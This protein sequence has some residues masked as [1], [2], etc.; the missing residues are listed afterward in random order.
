MK[1]NYRVL[2]I[3]KTRLVRRGSLQTW[4]KAEVQ[5]D[6]DSKPSVEDIEEVV[7]D[8]DDI[9]QLEENTEHAR[10]DEI[11]NQQRKQ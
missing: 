4:L 3:G 6:I 11:K 1:G 7:S 2:S 5:I 9:L 8:I 10:W